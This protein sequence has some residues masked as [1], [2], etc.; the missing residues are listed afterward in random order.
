MPFIPIP[1]KIRKEI[2]LDS[3]YKSCAL[4]GQSEHQCGGRITMEHAIEYAGKRLQKKWAI[5]P[6][7]AKGHEVDHFQD[8]G[9]MDKEMNRWV[10]LNR[11]TEFELKEISKAMDYIK[12]RNRL[13][14]I[15]GIYSPRTPEPK[16]QIMTNDTTSK[17]SWYLISSKDTE[18]IDKI[19]KFESTA[20][21]V[22]KLPREVITN[23][24]EDKY[25]QIKDQLLELDPELYKK[26]G[27]DK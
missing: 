10:A 11:A 3:F 1:T 18:Y 13:N 16:D 15:Y 8:A 23:A 5:I 20:L 25:L 2:D 17:R 19:R 9:T 12:E 22:R 21:G 14:T 4:W 27:F 6:I 7:C 24:I 26:L